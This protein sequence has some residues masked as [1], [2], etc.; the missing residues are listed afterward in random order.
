MFQ[1]IKERFKG[2]N[3]HFCV[4]GDGS[5]DCEGV[6]AMRWPFV[7]IYMLPG[8]DH[9]FPG[10]PVR[11]PGYYFAVV[12]GDPGTE[13]N[14]DGYISCLLLQIFQQIIC[15]RRFYRVEWCNLAFEHAHQ[16]TEYS[17]YPEIHAD[18]IQMVSL[19]G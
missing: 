10:L 15:R 19:V 16:R 7:K 13:N 18:Q 5:E 9:R 1:W 3:V 14:E 6:Q 4:H 12:Y 17:A 8:G 11:A 2:P